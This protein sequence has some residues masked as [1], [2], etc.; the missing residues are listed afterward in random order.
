LL[1]FVPI[2]ILQHL[3]GNGFVKSRLFVSSRAYLLAHFILV[4]YNLVIIIFQIWFLDVVLLFQFMFKSCECVVESGLFPRMVVLEHFVVL[5]GLY[6]IR[7]V[8]LFKWSEFLIHDRA[9]E[10]CIVSLSRSRKYRSIL[11][12]LCHGCLLI[13]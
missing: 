6:V 2:S 8:Q 3:F 4:L 9:K 1:W 7:I 10:T 5:I 13:I 12:T 11:S